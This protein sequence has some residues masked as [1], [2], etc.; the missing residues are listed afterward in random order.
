M[1]ETI[2]CYIVRDAD[3]WTVPN[4]EHVDS[5]GYPLN[6]EGHTAADEK[7]K[8]RAAAGR[9]QVLIKLANGKETIIRRY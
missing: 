7:A 2:T 4:T 5:I 6:T 3:A 8:E 9:P 1:A